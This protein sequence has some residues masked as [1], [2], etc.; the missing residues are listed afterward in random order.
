MI[1]N[2]TLLNP[3][4]SSPSTLPIRTLEEMLQNKTTQ[5]KEERCILLIIKHI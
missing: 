4:E 3:K 5:K 2:S 1:S